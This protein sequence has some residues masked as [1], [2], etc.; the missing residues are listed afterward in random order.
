MIAH[1]RQSSS[2]FHYLFGGLL[3]IVSV[4][5]CDFYSEALYIL[6]AYVQNIAGLPRCNA[7]NEKFVH[8]FLKLNII[9]NLHLV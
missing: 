5:Y 3:W 6:C 4:F 8:L 2:S 1:N 9:R 7:E